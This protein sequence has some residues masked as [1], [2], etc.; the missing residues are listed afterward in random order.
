[1]NEPIAL[2]PIGV[3]HN[4][5]AAPDEAH[6]EE[7]ISRIE[8]VPELQSGLEGIEEFSHLLIVFVFH[9]RPAGPQPLQVHPERRSDM[10]LVGVLATRSPR[11]PNPIGVTAVELLRRE[12]NVL[13]VRGLDAID[14]TPVL[15]IKPYLPRGDAQD[16]VR[17][18]NWIKRLWAEKR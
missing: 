11:R 18:P 1:V 4:D 15:D 7:V 3:V 8:V 10:P 6:W 16:E 5:V 12:G 9:R 13:T 14:S 2:F 17:V